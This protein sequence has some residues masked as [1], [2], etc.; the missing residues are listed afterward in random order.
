P[1]SGKADGRIGETGVIQDIEVL[2]PQLKLRTFTGQGEALEN[3]HIPVERAGTAQTPFASVPKGAIRWKLKSGRVEITHARSRAPAPNASICWPH[4][5]RATRVQ[6]GLRLI[7]PSH[8][9]QRI[10]SLCRCDARQLPPPED[11]PDQP[12]CP[13][14]R[15]QTP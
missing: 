6:S 2:E 10:A 3:A 5:T 13:G 4:L 7:C 9:R 15:R 14:Q 11:S 8:C 1:R 12:I